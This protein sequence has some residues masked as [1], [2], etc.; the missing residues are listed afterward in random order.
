MSFTAGALLD[1]IRSRLE[2]GRF[3]QVYCN[4]D[5]NMS[6]VHW[7]GFDMDYTLAIYRQAALDELTVGLTVKRL[8]E[9]HGYPEA[10][11]AVR[12]DPDFAIRGLTV[13]RQNGNIL[14]LDSHRWAG[15]GVHG[16][17][18]LS[19]A[20]LD[21]YRTHP[22]NIS[23]ERYRLLDTLFEPPEAFVL[24][25]LVSLLEAEGREV[26]Y[27]A[28]SDDVRSAIDTVHGD[29]SLKEPVLADLDR[30][31]ERDPEIALTLHRF[32]SAG[33]KLF[34]LTN[35]WPRYTDGVMRW[36][37]EGIH[38]DYPDWLSFFDIVI[39]GARKPDF[40][41]GKEPFI[42]TNPAEEKLGELDGR[43]QRG[44]IYLHGNLADFERS[45]GLGADQ[46]LYIGDH[47]YGDILRSKRDS[48][49]RTA[50]IVPELEAELRTARAHRELDED[51]QAIEREL[52]RMADAIHI[53]NELID[54]LLDARDTESL[55]DSERA[56]LED[57][58]R[59]L[60][61]NA[62][63]M[64]KRRRDTI[65]RSREV[66]AAFDASFHP[67]WG[68]LFKLGNEHSIFGEQV[69]TYACLYTSRVSNFFYY[70]PVHYYRTPRDLLPHEQS[71]ENPTQG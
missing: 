39:T 47:I 35:S 50:M 65:Q 44:Q 63:R 5:L 16:F 58:L 68:P 56:E 22:P 13:D 67:T 57:T 23:Q 7:I 18:P 2:H 40:F 31:V 55:S 36:L 9:Q 53:E 29:G 15:N 3:R 59:A 14:K 34:L 20:E 10:L 69:E 71:G 30:Y 28:V 8:I 17:R 64:Q 46:I 42:R 6:G 19:D 25:A 48:A 62:E 37:L 1:R 52:V 54:G 12:F 49:W 32:R 33:K 43:L 70:S 61:R 51:R 11:G 24:A 27:R 21:P 60:T 4:R 41:R 66:A 38:P 45:I 26:D